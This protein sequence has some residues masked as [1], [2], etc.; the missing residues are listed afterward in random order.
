MRRSFGVAILTC[1][2]LLIFSGAV[3]ASGYSVKKIGVLALNN[4]SRYNQ[5]GSIAA[6]TIT[7]NLTKLK[8]CIV[9]ERNELSRVFAEQSLGAK[10]YISEASAAELGGIL[11]LDYL[12]M[13]SADA[14]LVQESGR[15]YYNKKRN[16]NEWIEGTKKTTVVLTLKLIDA[17][18]GQIVW[19]DQTAITNYNDDLNSA[20]AEAAYDSVRKIYKFIPLQGYVIKSE[21]GQYVIDLGTNHN[22]TVGDVFEVNSASN[23]M[24]H[25]VTGELIV[26]KK[27]A[28]E[29]TVT[30]VFD[31]VC[32]AKFKDAKA[33]GDTDILPGDIVI[34]KLKKKPRG[35]LGLG[36]SGKTDF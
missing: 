9:V 32:I 26:M 17:K 28:G 13:G 27:N 36:W 21:A 23:T 1:L 24:R 16:R 34:K 29:I 6:E 18:N 31:S 3:F 22:V 7:A 10:G 25:P 30:E 19:S 11:G 12:L 2:V 15:Y 35:F 33:P 8:S 4:D 20:L 5:F 14:D